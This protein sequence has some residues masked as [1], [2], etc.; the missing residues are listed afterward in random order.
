MAVAICIFLTSLQMAG[1]LRKIWAADINTESW[2]SAPCLSPDKRD[3]YFASSRPGVMAEAIFMFRH[4]LPNGKWS[5]PEN[6][7]PEINTAGDESCSVYS[8]R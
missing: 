6:L 3:L 7:G 2:E 1:A 4:R 5:E 8:C